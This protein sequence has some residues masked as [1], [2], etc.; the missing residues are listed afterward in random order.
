MEREGDTITIKK[1]PY[2][3]LHHRDRMM[4]LKSEGLSLAKSYLED[5]KIRIGISN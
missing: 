4:Q 1:V 3:G 2:L 5:L